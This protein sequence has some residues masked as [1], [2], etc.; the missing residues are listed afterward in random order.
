MINVVTLLGK[1]LHQTDILEKP[2]PLL[3]VTAAGTQAAMVVAAVA[4]KY[5]NGLLLARQNALR[6]DISTPQIHEAA[7]IAQ[8]LSEVVWALPSYV[9]AAMAPELDPPIPCKRLNFWRS[10]EV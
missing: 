6:I 7:D 10:F 1:R 2:I 5:S 3:V 4:K 9:K 8:Y